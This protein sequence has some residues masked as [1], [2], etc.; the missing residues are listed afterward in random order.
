MNTRYLI[1][2][3]DDFG[4]SDG[5]NRGILRAH[6]QGIVTS[7]SLMVR[8]QAAQEAAAYARARPELGV[9]LHFDLGEW[10]YRNGKWGTV[11]CVVPTD[12]AV[13]VRTEVESQLDLFRTLMG[14][15]PTHLDSHQ[16]VHRDEPVRSILLERANELRVPLRGFDSRIRFEGSFYGQDGRG[17]PFP[18]NISVSALLELVRSLPRGITEL[19]CHPGLG[20]SPNSMYRRERAA[21]VEVL[22]DPRVR[23]AIVEQEI[24]LVSFQSLLF[25]SPAR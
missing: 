6:E 5:V 16:H 20:D 21:E 1:V 18:E 10:V 4:Q 9:G 24:E 19:G 23:R 17:A 3:A 7:A 14:R 11:Y 2:N 8:W 22:R 13:A 25:N 12:D 15:E